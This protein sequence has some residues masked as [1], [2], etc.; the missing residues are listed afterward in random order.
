MIENTNQ[1]IA[2]LQPTEIDLKNAELDLKTVFENAKPISGMAKM[3][4]LKV[5]NDDVAS[6]IITEDGKNPS[7]NENDLYID[8]NGPTVSGN[9]LIMDGKDRYMDGHNSIES[10]SDITT[11]KVSDWFAVEYEG[12]LYLGEVVA[13]DGDQNDGQVW[14]MQPARPNWK[15]SNLMDNVLYL[16]E[17]HRDT[18]IV[19]NHGHLKFSVMF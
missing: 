18:P 2:E 11:I 19:K 3:H 13:I 7:I 5:I 4:L 15:W 17:K 12:T 6:F 1:M 10:G 16:K 14:V 9:N 8:E